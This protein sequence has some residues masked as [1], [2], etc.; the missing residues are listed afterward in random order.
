[1][2]AHF[3]SPDILTTLGV[4]VETG[5][6]FLSILEAQPGLAYGGDLENVSSVSSQTCQNQTGWFSF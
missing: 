6:H 3:S 5:M 2:F 4:T 1:M